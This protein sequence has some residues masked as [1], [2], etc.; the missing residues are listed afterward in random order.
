MFTTNVDSIMS[1]FTKTIT[2]LETLA[3]K[4]ETRKSAH[5]DTINHHKNCADCCGIE[6]D[7]ALAIAS[8]L[9]GIIN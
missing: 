4:N 6:A 7:R 9:K 1:N 5:M 3:A 8:K 2:K